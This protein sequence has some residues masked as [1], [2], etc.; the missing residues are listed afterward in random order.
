MTEVG[1]LLTIR[2]EDSF[3]Y[4][5]GEDLPPYWAEIIVL[6]FEGQYSLDVFGLSCG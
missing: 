5:F 4:D 2:G 6:E 3:A 1:P